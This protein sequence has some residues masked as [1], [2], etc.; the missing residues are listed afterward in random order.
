MVCVTVA[1]GFRGIFASLGVWPAD[2]VRRRVRFAV[3]FPGRAWVC[4]CSASRHV[5]AGPA[6]PDSVCGL[7]ERVLFY[8]QVALLV[9]RGQM[10]IL[11][12][13]FEW[14][15][16]CVGSN[17]FRG[18]RVGTGWAALAGC[19]GVGDWVEKTD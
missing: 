19:G 10:R 18:Q 8:L 1:A 5:G 11:G 13:V 6:I 15:S 14:G 4:E 12:R 7:S 16:V 2:L 17:G 3:V 9:R